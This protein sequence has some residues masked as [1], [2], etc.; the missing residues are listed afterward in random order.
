MPS[1][2]KENHW[3]DKKFI[4]R[5]PNNKISRTCFFRSQ[6]NRKILPVKENKR[7]RRN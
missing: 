5:C 1:N 3:E 7:K 2:V 6:I 4:Q